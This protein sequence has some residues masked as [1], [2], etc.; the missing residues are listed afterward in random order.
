MK[1][2]ASLT[3]TEFD[4]WMARDWWTKAIKRRYPNTGASE[5]GVSSAA[6]AC[7]APSS[8]AYSSVAPPASSAPPSYTPPTV[9]SMPTTSSV[10]SILP[11]GTGYYPFPGAIN[12]TAMPTGTGTGLFPTG[13]TAIPTGFSTGYLPVPTAASS[14]GAGAAPTHTY[15]PWGYGHHRWAFS[16]VATSPLLEPVKYN[17]R[18]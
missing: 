4:A 7:A 9:S 3:I 12:G 1:A 17:W 14:S 15:N 16:R 6:P 2:G 5:E 18:N 8:A 10:V 13:G 11:T